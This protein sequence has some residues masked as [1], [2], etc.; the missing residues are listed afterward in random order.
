MCVVCD[1]Y[2]FATEVKIEYVASK[3]DYILKLQKK[4]MF[5]K[6]ASLQTWLEVG[7]WLSKLQILIPVS[8]KGG[9]PSSAHTFKSQVKVTYKKGKI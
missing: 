6:I 3:R 2:H 7:T 1:S 4:R 8:K 9:R 5:I